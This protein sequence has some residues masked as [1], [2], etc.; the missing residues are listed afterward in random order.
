MQKYKTTRE[1]GITRSPIIKVLIIV[2]KCISF[3]ISKFELSAL[4]G[5]KDRTQCLC[6]YRVKILYEL[7]AFTDTVTSK[8]TINIFSH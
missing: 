5:W 1:M 3:G 4:M 8:E 2:T 6:T 7:S